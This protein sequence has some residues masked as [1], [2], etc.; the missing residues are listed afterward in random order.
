LATGHCSDPAKVDGSSCSDA[1]A[2]TTGDTCTNGSCMS[3]NFAWSGVLDPIN[4]DGSSIFKLGST[5]PVKFQLTDPCASNSSLVAHIYV[6]KVLNMVTGSELE[7]T[8][9]SAADTGNTFRYAGNGQYI[10]NLATKPLS[11]GTWQIRIV[12]G[13]DLN[14]ND[15][16]GLVNISLKK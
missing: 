6:A 1:N 16:N 2:C 9:T 15:I 14:G 4:W 3:G 12:L 7:A 13:R 8:S 11:V 10:F 5:I